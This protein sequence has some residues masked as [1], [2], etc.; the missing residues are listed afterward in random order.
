MWKQITY[1]PTGGGKSLCYQIPALLEDG[2]TWDEN[3]G[4]IERYSVLHQLRLKKPVMS[5]VTLRNLVIPNLK[6]AKK[7]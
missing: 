6:P 4:P 5:V 3:H 2:L 7:R 1:L